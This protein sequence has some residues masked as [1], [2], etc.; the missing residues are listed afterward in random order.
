MGRS[1]D[2]HCSC[3]YTWRSC[4]MSTSSGINRP[5]SPYI[6]SFHT[7]CNAIPLKRFPFILLN[8]LQSLMAYAYTADKPCAYPSDLFLMHSRTLNIP[9]YTLAVCSACASPFFLKSQLFKH[10]LQLLIFDLPLNQPI[11]S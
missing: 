6:N 3:V 4:F 5:T 8:L 7:I 2:S 9:A 11:D 1:T 10:I